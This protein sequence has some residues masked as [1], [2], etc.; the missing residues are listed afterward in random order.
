MLKNAI[1]YIGE[2]YLRRKKVMFG[3]KSQDR[4]RH[5]LVIGKT[6]TGKSTLLQNLAIQDIQNGAGV[7]FISAQSAKAER[8]LSFIPE[9]RAKDVIYLAA[10]NPS[11][12]PEL[13]LHQIMDTKKILLINFNQDMTSIDLLTNELTSAMTT[14][15]STDNFYIYF[16]ELRL[17]GEE[18]LSRLLSQATQHKIGLISSFQVSPSMT[19]GTKV[20][21]RTDLPGDKA[22]ETKDVAN[23]K[24]GQAYV[25]LS[26]DGQ[27]SPFFMAQTMPPVQ[28]SNTSFKDRILSNHPTLSPIQKEVPED[29]LKRILQ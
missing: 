4:L 1:T 22:L 24:V 20:V 12:I 11:K 9:S 29:V 25:T 6:G 8:L 18:T 5:I 14:R 15:R 28:P 23:L 17:A 10:P 3:I 27:S 16:D 2:T 21:F 26:I 7:V 13:N 19:V